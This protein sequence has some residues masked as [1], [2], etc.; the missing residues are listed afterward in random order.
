MNYKKS[1]VNFDKIRARFYETYKQVSGNWDAI[2]K[3]KI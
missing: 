2:L 3:L 1:L